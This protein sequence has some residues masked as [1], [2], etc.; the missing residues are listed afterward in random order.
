MDELNTDQQIKLQTTLKSHRCGFK[1]LHAIVSGF[2]GRMKWNKMKWIWE[3][4]TL[5]MFDFE[6]N[7]YSILVKRALEL[8]V[9]QLKLYQCEKCSQ[10][11]CFYYHWT[12][13][14]S[15]TLWNVIETGATKTKEITTIW[16]FMWMWQRSSTFTGR[17]FVA[18][19]A[20]KRRKNQANKYQPS[21]FMHTFAWGTRK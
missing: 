5:D 3:D 15:G 13:M 6:W 16:G 20:A 21:S 14:K 7:G 10:Q 17:M 2:Y 8:V 11:S 9:I 18:G 19:I 1:K 12:G 4:V